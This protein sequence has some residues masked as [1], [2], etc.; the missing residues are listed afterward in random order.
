VRI[1]CICDTHG[2]RA[3]TEAA[4]N[5][6]AYRLPI[7]ALVKQLVQL[8]GVFVVGTVGAVTS[9]RT[10]RHWITGECKPERQAQLRFAYRVA[11]MVAASSSAC[12]VQSWFKGANT[13]LGDSA[14]AILIRDDFSEDTRHAILRAARRLES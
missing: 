2:R 8:A 1:V 5:Q 14:P 13:S 4:I 9:E 6:T 10:V 7:A 12:L 11:R 3:L